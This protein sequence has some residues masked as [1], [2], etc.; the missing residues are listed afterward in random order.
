MNTKL[1]Y[2]YVTNIPGQQFP[3]TIYGHM[4]KVTNSWIFHNS[5]IHLL[6]VHSSIRAIACQQSL[7]VFGY[8]SKTIFVTS[9]VI[10]VAAVAVVNVAAVAD[11]N[12]AAVAIISV[13]AVVDM[14]VA[15]VAL[16][17]FA[18]VEVVNVAAV[19]VVNVAAVALIY[20]AAVALLTS[21][22]TPATN[23]GVRCYNMKANP[24]GYLWSKNKCYQISSCQDMNSW[25][26][27]IQNYTMV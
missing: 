6:V 18:A 27:S 9:A 23:P 10:Y 3:P 11:S 8:V 14:N 4:T 12:V 25:K 2:K 24:T 26:A 16:I 21:S 7:T 20:V 1:G 5:E 19:A 22:P 15:T 17:Y 13:A